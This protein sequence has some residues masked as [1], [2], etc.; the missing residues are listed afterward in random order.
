MLYPW[1]LIS[2]H[3]LHFVLILISHLPLSST[4]LLLLQEHK[5]QSSLSI[6]LGHDYKFTQNPAYTKYSIHRV[7]DQRS[8]AYTGYSIHRVH[9]TLSIAYTKY[10]VCH[11]HHTPRTAFTEF[12]ICLVQHIPST[13]YTKYSIHQ[14]QYPPSTVF[15]QDCSIFISS[16]RVDR[17]MLIQLAI[18][19]LI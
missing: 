4:T 6:S 9:H 2:A 5:V 1:F 18:Y 3:I 7:E 11:V 16:I 14:V 19:L 15:T 13:A 8:T 12:S 17:W 10:N